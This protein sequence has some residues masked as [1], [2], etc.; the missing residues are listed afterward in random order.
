MCPINHVCVQD[1]QTALTLFEQILNTYP[2]SSSAQYGLA[3][4]LDQLA[5]LNRSNTILKRAIAEY[6]KL[7][8]LDKQLNDTEFKSAAERCI[9][10]MRFMGKR[11]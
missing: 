3:K 10:R 5:D 6:E 9:E 11:F 7:I 2:T 4:T 1:P 8:A